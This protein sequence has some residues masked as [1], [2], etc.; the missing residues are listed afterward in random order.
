MKVLDSRLD[1]TPDADSVK[2][3]VE[4]RIRNLLCF[5]ELQSLNDTGKFENIH[6]FLVHRAALAELE[7]L[8]KSDRDKF[9]NEYSN[10]KT[11]I[12][13]YKS[14]LG[15][16]GISEDDTEKYTTLLLKHRERE[17]IFKKILNNGQSN[18]SL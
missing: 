2:E 13:R 9:I 7:E 6:P 14:I 3:M 10:C 4:L 15:K 18:H 11:N 1:D 8:W 16:K 12:R 17:T 5:R